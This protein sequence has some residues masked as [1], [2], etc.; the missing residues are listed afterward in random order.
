M[1]EP[2]HAEPTTPAARSRDSLSRFAIKAAIVC[3]AIVVTVWLTTDIITGQ[4]EGTVNRLVD[5]QVARITTQLQ[6][7]TRFDGRDLWPRI[8]RT[9]DNA[10]A[11]KYDLPPEKQQKIIADVRAVSER[12]RPFFVELSAAIAGGQSAGPQTGR[13]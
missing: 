3:A 7:K 4:I 5:R 6:T 2:H 13:Q 9:L 1:E 12:W 11:A 8:E 10:V